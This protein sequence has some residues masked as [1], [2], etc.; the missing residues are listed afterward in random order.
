M[1][2]VQANYCFVVG[3]APILP[4]AKG[5]P[6][7]RDGDPNSPAAVIAMERLRILLSDDLESSV[8]SQTQRT[9]HQATYRGKEMRLSEDQ[10]DKVNGLLDK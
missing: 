6:P 10:L 1:L 2:L 3:Q 5:P 9:K 8:V 4:H 7:P